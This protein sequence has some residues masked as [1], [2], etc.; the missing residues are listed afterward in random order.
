VPNSPIIVLDQTPRV[1]AESQAQGDPRVQP[2]GDQQ[3]PSDMKIVAYIDDFMK[4]KA[5]EERNTYV[6][7]LAMPSKQL[8]IIGLRNPRFF[9]YINSVLQ[10]LMGIPQLNWFALSIRDAFKQHRKKSLFNYHEFLCS[11]A[12]AKSCSILSA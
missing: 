3:P 2:K 6:H 11:V 5:P 12:N 10:C 8:P 7:I 1:Q 9:C 4:H